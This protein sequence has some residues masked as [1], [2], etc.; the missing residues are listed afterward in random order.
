[1][2]AVKKR[3]QTWGTGQNEGF[4]YIGEVEGIR[5]YIEEEQ[6]VLADQMLAARHRHTDGLGLVMATI[7]NAV[8]GTALFVIIL[9]FG[10]NAISRLDVTF[11]NFFL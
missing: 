2:E 7:D 5:R 4:K 8:R 9:Y 11:N 10:R 6:Q 1:M 3:S